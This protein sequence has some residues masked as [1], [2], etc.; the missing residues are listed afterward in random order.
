MQHLRSRLW[1][2]LVLVHVT[3]LQL[4]AVGASRNNARPATPL[5]SRVPPIAA[6]IY[7]SGDLLRE[8]QP[9]VTASLNITRMFNPTLPIYA[10]TTVEALQN[11]STVQM[12]L[13]QRVDMRLAEPY[14]QQGSRAHQYEVN[15][16]KANATYPMVKLAQRF[17][18]YADLAKVQGHQRILTLVC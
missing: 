6:Y 13:E 18:L 4:F 12:L 1:V 16:N 8:Q 10:V 14:L 3:L 5:H 11:S 2:F 7:L 9:W 15:R 17:C